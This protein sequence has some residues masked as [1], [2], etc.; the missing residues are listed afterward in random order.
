MEHRRRGVEKAK[1]GH[2][3]EIKVRHDPVLLPPPP[4]RLLH[5]Q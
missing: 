1:V 3:K 2:K 4:P 5:L